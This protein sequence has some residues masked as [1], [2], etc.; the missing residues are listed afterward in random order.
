MHTQPIKKTHSFKTELITMP[1]DQ[2]RTT[3]FPFTYKDGL[4]LS[5]QD[6]HAWLNDE[7]AF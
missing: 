6:R 7:D 1:L 3:V 2:H 5:L 4:M